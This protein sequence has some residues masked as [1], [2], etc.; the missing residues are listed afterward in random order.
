MKYYL[1]FFLFTV[2]LLCCGCPPKHKMGTA[3]YTGTDIY[4]AG[5]TFKNGQTHAAYL[6][7]GNIMPFLENDNV[8]SHASEIVA[9]KNLIYITGDY[10]GHP[11]YW[12]NG[13]RIML[14]DNNLGGTV[15]NI[16]LNQVFS[17]LIGN[18]KTNLGE[19]AVIW[20]VGDGARYFLSNLNSNAIS[21]SDNLTISGDVYESNIKKACYWKVTTP[22]QNP[23]ITE[24]I[25]NMAEYTGGIN[26]DFI[27]GSQKDQNS[28]EHAGYWNKGVFSSFQNDSNPSR[29]NDVYIK[30]DYL[31]PTEYFIGTHN[32]SAALWI[33]NKLTLLSQNPNSAALKIYYHR[34]KG[35]YILGYD[36]MNGI[37]EPCYWYNGLTKNKLFP[38]TNDDNFEATSMSFADNYEDSKW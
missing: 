31:D 38:N 21:C 34:D 25:L 16:Y 18:I 9:G 36:S 28:I 15:T 32:G 13:E 6:K 26:E 29:A 37:K 33:N 30:R 3:Y 27:A 14:N 5:T 17:F 10:N 12:K 1:Y 4:I 35:L 22:G 24:H 7:N 19:R 2:T 11:C 23:V 20:R 8:T